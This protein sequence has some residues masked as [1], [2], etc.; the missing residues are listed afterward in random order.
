[1]ALAVHSLPSG[2]NRHAPF[3]CW[4]AKDVCITCTRESRP[5]TRPRGDLHRE[6]PQ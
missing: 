5:Q 2:R 4:S 6:I 1:L 3:S